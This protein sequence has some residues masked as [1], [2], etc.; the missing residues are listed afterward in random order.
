MSPRSPAK[1]LDRVAIGCDCSSQSAAV[2]VFTGRSEME[3]DRAR[4]NEAATCRLMTANGTWAAVKWTAL[5]I[6]GSRVRS[7]Y[8][9]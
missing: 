4:A 9:S 6:T 3:R 8:S 5:E 2:P 7:P 1:P